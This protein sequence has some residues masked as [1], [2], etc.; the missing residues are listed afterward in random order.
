MYSFLKANGFSRHR[1]DTPR[2]IQVVKPLKKCCQ[3]FIIKKWLLENDELYG[4]TPTSFKDVDQAVIDN[5]DDY[6]H[7]LVLDTVHVVPWMYVTF[8]NQN[9]V[10]KIAVYLCIAD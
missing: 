5:R 10:T 7:D 6:V 9:V 3:N 4:K 1:R 2:A 8:N